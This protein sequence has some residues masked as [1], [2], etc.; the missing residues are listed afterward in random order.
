M[1]IMDTLYQLNNSVLMSNKHTCK[2]LSN[3]TR[4]LPYSKHN[5]MYHIKCYPLSFYYTHID[6]S[7][8]LFKSVL[9]YGMLRVDSNN[10]NINQSLMFFIN[11]RSFI[12]F[13]NHHDIPWPQR[14]SLMSTGLLRTMIRSPYPH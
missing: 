5:V 10:R 8:D 4:H 9:N 12:S 1:L 14:C 6:N 2:V 7:V 13:M 3:L 11:A